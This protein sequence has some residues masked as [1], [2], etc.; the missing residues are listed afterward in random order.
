MEVLVVHC[1]SAENLV[2]EAV[3]HTSIDESQEEEFSS[4]VEAYFGERG[5]GEIAL[6]HQEFEHVLKVV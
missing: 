2:H 6:C 4:A 3:V 1:R 5:M